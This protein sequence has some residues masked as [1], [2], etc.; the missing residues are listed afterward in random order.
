MNS[1]NNPAQLNLNPKQISIILMAPFNNDEKIPLT[2]DTIY[3][4]EL[5]DKKGMSQTPYITSVIKYP[6]ELIDK[7]VS[8]GY[9]KLVSF[10]FKKSDFE[11]LLRSYMKSPPSS[12]S[13]NEILEYNAMIMLKYLFPTYP[14]VNNISSSYN[15]YIL[16]NGNSISEMVSPRSLFAVLKT[17]AKQFSYIV[18]NG[19]TYTIA[20][21]VLLND[22]LNNPI[23]KNVIDEYTEYVNWSNEES[24]RIDNELKTGIIKLVNKFDK[25]KNDD[26][27]GSLNIYSYVDRFVKI[28]V[29]Q[30][31]ESK[32]STV[33]RFENINN[34]NAYVDQIV[35]SIHQIYEKY[36]RNALTEVL[37]KDKRENTTSIYNFIISF[38]QS[39]R[40]IKDLYN[41]I[42]DL[43]LM[44]KTPIEFSN[45][46]DKLIKESSELNMMSIIKNEYIGPRNINVKL[47]EK[48]QEITNLLR[49][50]YNT[51]IK[52]M[53]VIKTIISPTREST[54]VVLQ[55]SINNYSQNQNTGVRFNHIM[56]NVSEK[57]LF[58][59]IQTN[60]NQ[61]ID[62]KNY[63]N[64]GISRI[65]MNELAKPQ[66]EIYVS[67]DLI[68]NEY[69]KD[70]MNELECVDGFFLGKIA[71][72]LFKRVNPHI[73]QLH[74][75]FL[76][77]SEINNKNTN[78]S[79]ISPVTTTDSI[80]NNTG[81]SNSNN[82]STS[83]NINVVDNTRTDVT[84]NT[85]NN[86]KTVGGTLRKTR[87]YKK[88]RK[89]QNTRRWRK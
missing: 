31:K 8:R 72:N 26:K 7:L 49:T 73:V 56:E 87:K 21:T 4:P 42:L 85:I 44:T 57:Y 76:S 5:K 60:M 78:D 36:G 17:P 81:D 82:T 55:E 50:K 33:K 11:N 61:N 22:L 64:I 59:T 83:N 48:N 77:Q 53:D 62:L 29:D 14:S 28:V 89:I 40:D 86:N 88:K 65:N 13:S 27:P 63:M 9:Q 68:E 19:K 67:M 38:N 66:Y 24:D 41:M 39:L 2:L 51:Y 34:F 35:A 37:E 23:Y 12:S 74:S 1:N 70:N 32:F 45:N 15:E 18:V 58:K 79:N 10:F 84:E 69:N 52:F 6:I 25:D 3:H 80:A 43:K 16:Q 75:I 30:E 47:D 54:N 71:E 46:L 20:K